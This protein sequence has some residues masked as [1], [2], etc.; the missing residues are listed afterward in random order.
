VKQEKLR[1][2]LLAYE[3]AALLSCA[4]PKAGTHAPKP[5]FGTRYVVFDKAT[6][7]ISFTLEPNPIVQHNLSLNSW[8]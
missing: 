8:F 5:K 4:K 7:K 2:D 6:D 3:W 1:I